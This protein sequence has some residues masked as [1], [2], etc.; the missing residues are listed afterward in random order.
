MNR[1]Y[2]K[3]KNYDYDSNED[4]SDEEAKKRKRE[5]RNNTQTSNFNNNNNSDEETDFRRINRRTDNDSEIRRSRKE[6]GSRKDLSSRK[7]LRLTS[8][9][10]LKQNLDNGTRYTSSKSLLQKPKLT[11]LNTTQLQEI[12]ELAEVKRERTRS[13]NSSSD[14]SKERRLPMFDDKRTNNFIEGNPDT[15]GT[16]IHKSN[17]MLDITNDKLSDYQPNIVSNDKVNNFISS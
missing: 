3:A 13:I 15:R 14:D 8:T 11:T 12:R 10:S 1:T 4:E 6:L 17:T 16:F 5:L 7:D 2:S 9:K